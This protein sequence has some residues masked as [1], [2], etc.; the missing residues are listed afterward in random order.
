M[1][2]TGLDGLRMGCVQSYVRLTKIPQKREGL[3][4][5]YTY[6]KFMRAFMKTSPTKD[7][8]QF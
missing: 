4:Y 6:M 3:G 5:Y 7:S 1:I 2:V 8:V